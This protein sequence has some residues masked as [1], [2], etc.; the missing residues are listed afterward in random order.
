MHLFRVS[1]QADKKQIASI[2]EFERSGVGGCILAFSVYVHSV[3]LF[4]MYN[5]SSQPVLLSFHR[6]TSP[7]PLTKFR[8]DQSL[9]G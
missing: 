8:R 1:H 3:H 6:M 5:L 9:E 4:L 2:L 7:Q